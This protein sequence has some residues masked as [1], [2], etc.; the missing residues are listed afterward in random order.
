MKI[1]DR[2]SQHSFL[3]GIVRADSVVLDLGG[4]RGEFSLGIRERYGWRSLAVEP[5]PALAAHLRD[6]GIEVVEAAV[7]SEDG[8]AVFT[9]DPGHEL[10]GSLMGVDVVGSIMT[11][12]EARR[13][14]TVRT[15]S[16]ASLLAR[17]G[18]EV[19]LVKVDIEGA[20]LDMFLLASDETLMSVRQFTVEFHDY[21]Y[22]SLSA[23]TERAK[24]RLLA[25]GFWMMRA[26]PNNKDI[27]FVHPEFRPKALEAVY[28][29]YWLRNLNG[30]WRMGRVLFTR[31][32]A[33]LSRR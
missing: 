7:A 18:G 22:P 31:L 10:T 4:N 13:T 12:E 15:M 30:F 33:W 3:P 17:C 26:G 8:E 23:Q 5:T 14:S 27:L 19:D 2:I 21:W 24:N 28:V 32:G 16:L 9:Y 29:G 11:D 20:E 1:L 25:L 6:A